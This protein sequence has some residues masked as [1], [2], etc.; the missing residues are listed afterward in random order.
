MNNMYITYNW[1][2]F[3]VEK[4]EKIKKERWFTFQELIEWGEIIDIVEHTK[5]EYAWQ[6]FLMIRYEKQLW[7]IPFRITKYKLIEIATAFPCSREKKY[8]PEYFN[9]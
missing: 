5:P 4:N 2:I 6:K 3:S 1:F 9:L 8:Y 7:K